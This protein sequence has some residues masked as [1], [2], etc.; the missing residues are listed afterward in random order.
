DSPERDYLINSHIHYQVLPWLS[1]DVR[2]QY[3]H[4]LSSLTN[5]YHADSY[6]VRDQVNRFYQPNGPN[7][8]P[9]PL[10]GIRNLTNQAYNAH[11]GRFQLSDEKKWGMHRLSGIVGWEIRDK[12]GEGSSNRQYSYQRAG[13]IVVANS[14]YLTSYPQ[15]H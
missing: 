4:I 9:I 12:Q 15:Y 5:Y 10:G 14:D 11:Q 8:Y 7:K 1:A 2:Y 3:Q 13:N 6:Y